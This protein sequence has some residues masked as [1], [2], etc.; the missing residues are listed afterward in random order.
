[1]TRTQRSNLAAVAMFLLIALVV[2]GGMAWASR[3]SLQ[4]TEEQVTK[5]HQ[6]KVD[7]A[8]W[9]L[10][11][12][13]AGIINSETARQWF[14][15][16]A[17]QERPVVAVYTNDGREL[18][19]EGAILRSSLVTE[20]PP[21]DWIDLYFQQA[22]T[23][24]LTSPQI[25]NELGTWSDDHPQWNAAI[26]FRR[27]RTLAWL[28]KAL[29]RIN[30]QERLASLGNGKATQGAKTSA[31][32]PLDDEGT[33]A[34][35]KRTAGVASQ[36]RIQDFVRKSKTLRESQQGYVKPV[37][38][39]D[40][41]GTSHQGHVHADASGGV[42]ISCNPMVAFWIGKFA[43]H[44]KLAFM[45]EC[46][47][48]A[49]VF[50]QGFVGDWNMLKPR[51]LSE[52]R[53]TFPSADLVPV[54]D[55]Q[56]FSDTQIHNL[57]VRLVVAGIPGGAANMAWNEIRGTLLITWMSAAAVLLVAGW[58]LRNL[59]AL[60]ERRLQFAYGVTHE[61]R[62]PLTTFRLYSDML[63]A[64]LVPES[65]KQEYLETLDRESLR[66]TSLVEE[67]LEYARL[68][69]HKVKLNP[70]STNAASC[71]SKISETLEKR[72]ADHA[73]EPRTENA[74][75]NGT[76]L[77]TDV[78]LVNRIA[79]VLVNNACRHARGIENATVLVR[80]G[81]EDAKIHL[82][83]IDSGPG[84][85][86]ADLRSIFKPFRRGHGADKAAQGGIGLGLALARSWAKLLGGRLELAA[87][88]HAELGGAHFRLTIPVRV[89][90]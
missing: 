35:T 3:A 9:A 40:P 1:M 44:D 56:E 27:R 89:K 31:E 38:C 33:V 12:Y 68:E 6:R 21:Y 78:D 87:R 2:V 90:P 65:A 72:C 32:R 45:R 20:A 5:G 39:V 8:V 57:P 22:H 19:V 51:L 28:E 18:D 83:V 4:L 86:R 26:D 79:T 42:P 73:I 24:E 84:I 14:E 13:M 75:S 81:E 15:Y 46:H 29:P 34:D 43:D 25:S 30:L 64:G 62:T 50:F 59:V 58:G 52:I 60:T 70:T 37:D 41:D 16:E 67:V 53:E 11:G 66:L 63:A 61:L 17:L 71:L 36:E 48:G 88:H 76:T 54:L 47:K 69:N 77:C 80:L 85:D 55:D 82:D 7:T 74:I 10:A 49:E 23:G